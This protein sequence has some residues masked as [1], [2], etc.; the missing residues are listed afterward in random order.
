MGKIKKMKPIDNLFFGFLFRFVTI[1]IFLQ[2]NQFSTLAQ[3]V[4]DLRTFGYVTPVKNQQSC[5]SCWAF[6]AIAA[7]ES[8]WLKTS[9]GNYSLSED[10]LIDCHMF[11]EA[12]CAGGNLYMVNAL[13]S[14]H[15][16]TLLSYIDPYTPS[17]SNCPM[18]STFPP[19][20]P[21]YTEEIRFLPKNI[22]AVKQALQN[23]GVIATTM[24]FNP[25]NYNSSNFKYYDN[26]IDA[27]DLAYPHGVS[28]AGWN[29]TMTFQNAPSLGG[30]IIKD[31]YGTTWAQSGYFY[32]SYHDAGILS[33]TAFFPS[34]EY[35]P[36]AVNKSNV[37]YYDQFGWVDNFGFNNNIAYALVKYNIVPYN[38]VVSA[39]QIKRIGTYAVQDNSNITFEL[40][41]NFNS[42]I[43]SGL[44]ATKNL[45]CSYKGFYT[46]NLDLPSDSVGSVIYI[47]VTYQAPAGTLLP[48]P[49]EKYEANHTSAVSLS[50]GCCWVS[51]NGSTWLPSGQ[52][53][54]YSHDLCIKMYTEDAPLA[55]ISASAVSCCQMEM[56]Q[57]TDISPAP[58]D[59]IRWLLNG[60]FQGNMPVFNHVFSNPG[61]YY[62]QL[63]A[64]SGNNNDTASKSIDVFQNPG[65]PQI[66]LS[67][68]TLI[69]SSAA[70]YQWYDNAGIIPGA[71][72]YY[73]VP[74]QNGSYR[75]EITD[76]NGCH[77]ISLPYNYSI[78]ALNKYHNNAGVILYPN[79]VTDHLVIESPKPIQFISITD[80]KGTVLFQ[81][82][83]QIN[84]Q[85][86]ET[87]GF[88]AL[89]LFVSIVTA[90]NIYSYKVIKQ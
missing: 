41:R 64:F 52:G 43:L 39:Q 14:R 7:I 31:S 6:A 4:Y 1:I 86:I 30:W 90:D 28:I 71:N 12:P 63:V 75:V 89:V 83:S 17:L 15:G 13:L 46:A 44:I 5:G 68:D 80:S 22:T 40:Y 77:N 33:E 45:F 19:T 23:Y 70:F 55:R 3:T 26:Q 53:T 8:N 84:R 48:I 51:S 87:V 65:V 85:A 20:P 62:L 72:L 74:L 58:K 21:A 78:A 38:G 37:Y 16:G 42:G 2:T 25:A 59:S 61:Q 9:F 49:V 50:S 79:P 60:V 18:Q 10:N 36:L 56:L 82:S 76:L 73:Y 81:S 69:S 34:K 57:F 66:S 27:A 29:D 32:V 67:Q 24:F 11:D 54:T 88:N 35:I 47:K